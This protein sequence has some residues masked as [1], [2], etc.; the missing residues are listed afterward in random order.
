MKM[1]N[2]SFWGSHVEIFGLSL[3]FDKPV[4]YSG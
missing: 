4:C 1:E 2:H 3:H